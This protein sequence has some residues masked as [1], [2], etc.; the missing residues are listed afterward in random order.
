VLCGEAAFT[1]VNITDR[2]EKTINSLLKLLNSTNANVHERI[3]EAMFVWNSD[4][5]QAGPALL[6]LSLDT[7]SPARTAAAIAL[8]KVAPDLATNVLA[9]LKEVALMN[10]W[11]GYRAREMLASM[12]SKAKPVADEML[13]IAMITEQDY[14]CTMAKA[15]IK[16]DPEKGRLLIPALTQQLNAG[17]N[18]K[19]TVLEAL[20]LLGDSAASA[21]PTI[22]TLLTNEILSVR[23]AATNAHHAITSAPSA[24]ST[25]ATPP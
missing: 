16:I 10:Y 21:L 20:S 17:L 5:Q 12:G 13:K 2:P 23:T 7:N 22:K 19:T 15:V 11:H 9:Q 3:A 1:L 18:D 6:R 8:V 24:A 4:G 14:E 25:P